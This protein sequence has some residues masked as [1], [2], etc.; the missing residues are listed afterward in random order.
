MEKKHWLLLVIDIIILLGATILGGW[1][2][3]GLALCLCGLISFF[4]LPLLFPEDFN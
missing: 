1:V 4:I 3:F 2:G